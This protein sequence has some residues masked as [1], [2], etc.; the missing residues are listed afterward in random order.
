MKG[1]Q[2]TSNIKRDLFRLLSGIV[3]RLGV[4]ALPVG[5]VALALAGLSDRVTF[6][7]D[8]GRAPGRDNVRTQRAKPYR[9]EVLY[10]TRDFVDLV[11]ESRKR[12]RDLLASFD[13]FE[14]AREEASSGW[15]L[16][17]KQVSLAHEDTITERHVARASRPTVVIDR[18]SFAALLPLLQ[19]LQ[20]LILEGDGTG[21]GKLHKSHYF[22]VPVSRAKW[23]ILERPDFDE[24]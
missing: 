14:S 21:S 11:T 1:A 8:A 19:E 20:G 24:R 9:L 4:W 16:A 22:A 10:Y 7:G 13:A 18:T 3:Q 12:G 17:V 5:V 2:A 6:I 15:P 23:H